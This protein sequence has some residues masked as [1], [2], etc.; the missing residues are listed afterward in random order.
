[1][2]TPQI[3][4][5]EFMQLGGL[6]LGGLALG[7]SPLRPLAH[8]AQSKPNE[9]A[10]LVRVAVK[11]MR[12][13]SEPSYQSNVVATRT[14]DQLLYVFEEFESDLGPDF[15]PRWYKVDEGYAHTA[16]LQPTSRP[17]G[18]PPSPSGRMARCGTRSPTSCSRSP[19]TC[20]PSTCAKCPPGS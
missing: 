2:S 9:A 12:L 17:T 20:W 7:A 8:P 10:G 18:S 6:A 4:R 14:R 11:E 3:S 19:I 16:Y 5:K 1:M 13:Y 15:N